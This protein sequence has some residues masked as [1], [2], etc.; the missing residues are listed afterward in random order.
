LSRPVTGT[1][2]I[3]ILLWI[4]M[5]FLGLSQFRVGLASIPKDPEKSDHERAA[6]SGAV[7]E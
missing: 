4:A 5:L 2:Y 1:D 6:V 7:S 3:N